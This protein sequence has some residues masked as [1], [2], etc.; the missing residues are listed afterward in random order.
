MSVS[1]W[2]KQGVVFATMVAS[3]LMGSALAD[4]QARVVRLSDV[5]GDVQIERPNSKGFE[6]AFL[7]MPVIQGSKLRTNGGGLAEVQF[8]DGSA[9]RLTP[10]TTVSFPQLFLNNSG[11]HVSTA[12][13]DSGT[14]YVN[15]RGSKNDELTLQFGPETAVLNRSAHM[16][17]EM[18]NDQAVLAVFDGDV[19]VN[20]GSG[21]MQVGKK[22]TATFDLANQGHYELAKNLET[23]P[24]DTWDKQQTQYAQTY[25]TSGMSG[26]SP[27]GYGMADLNYYGNYYSLP[28][29]GTVWQ[30]YFTGAGWSPFNNGAWLYY[31]GYG[32]NYTSAY[33]WGWTPYHSGSWLYAPSYGWVWQPGNSWTGLGYVPTVSRPPSN[34]TPPKPPSVPG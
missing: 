12:A 13:L 33:P 18:D 15:F 22:Q 5:Q 6:K 26:Y 21:Q 9:I 17:V 27:Y 2:C 25:T 29:Y 31:P 32:Y 19:K 1:K 4:S 3:V 11:G 34:F 16:R 23:D 14:A 28:G 20:G 8:E 10:G 7:N 30:P 24:Y